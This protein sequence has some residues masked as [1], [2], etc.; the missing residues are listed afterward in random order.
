MSFKHLSALLLLASFWGSS[1][2][3]MK[4]GAPAL[5]P[6]FLIESRVLLATIFL[7]AYAFIM[8]QKLFLK[9][10]WKQYII[11]GTINAAIPFVLIAASELYLT[12]SLASIIN[13]TTPLFTA[14]ISILW[15]KETKS[16]RTFFGLILGCIGVIILV[17]WNPIAFNMKLVIA[18]MGSCLAALFYGIGGVY[19]KIAFQHTK[20]KPLELAIGQQFGA[21]IVLM[22]LALLYLPNQLPSLSVSFSVLGLA[23][24]STGIGYL[25]YFYLIKNIGPTKT[26]SVTFLVPIVGIVW[27]VIFLHE[28]VTA[29]TFIGLITILISIFYVTDIKNI[30]FRTNE[31][32]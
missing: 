28:P 26:L 23:I 2:L 31:K 10:H 22:P 21:S 8:K 25:L 32:I 9:V 12:S 3:F 15:M 14:I 19:S 27:G 4:I 7:L 24:F 20:I 17:G 11:L 6:F 18:I 13:A 16:S 30:F 5:G 29:S 1:F